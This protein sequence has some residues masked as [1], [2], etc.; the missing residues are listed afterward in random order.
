[1]AANRNDEAVAGLL[2]HYPEAA[3]MNA[4]EAVDFLAHKL[5]PLIER[6]NTFWLGQGQQGLFAL[7][8]FYVDASVVWMDGNNLL[9]IDEDDLPDFYGDD[10]YIL[11]NGKCVTDWNE[12]DSAPDWYFVNHAADSNTTV[13]WKKAKRTG[14]V[15]MTWTCTRQI[16]P[17]DMITMT[18]ADNEGLADDPNENA[19][20]G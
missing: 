19:F 13:R 6:R 8:T 1:M 15:T 7:T 20:R 3:N 14:K 17:G 16:E 18:Y 4:Q 5:Y 9:F 2:A 12:G 10:K 11:R